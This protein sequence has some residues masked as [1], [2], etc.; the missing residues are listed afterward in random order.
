MVGQL[1]VA[2]LH[3]FSDRIDDSERPARPRTLARVLERIDDDP[4]QA[5]RANRPSPSAGP[6]HAMGCRPRGLDH[7]Q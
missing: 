1:L 3:N 7:I 6:R 2:Q 4:A 5:F